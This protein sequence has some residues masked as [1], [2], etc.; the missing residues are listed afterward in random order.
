MMPPKG[1][2]T[3]TVQEKTFNNLQDYFTK[4]EIPKKQHGL[5]LTLTL[6]E[7]QRERERLQRLARKI[8]KIPSKFLE[9]KIKKPVEIII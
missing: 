2:K 7:Q 9:I 1:F 6:R 4:L 5:F 3:I 8:K